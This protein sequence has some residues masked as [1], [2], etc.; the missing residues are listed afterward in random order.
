VRR[1]CTTLLLAICALTLPGCLGRTEPESTHVSG[2]VLTIYSSLPSHGPAAPMAAAI[3][4]GERLALAEAGGEAGG[5]HIRLEQLDS[6][7]QDSPLWSPD[8]ISANADRAVKDPTTIA[9]LGELGFGATAVSLPITNAAGLLQVSPTDGL[10]SLTRTPPGR[11]R[12]GP[13][14][15]YPSDMRSFLRLVPDDLL[16]TETLLGRV[17]ATGAQRLAVIYDA[18]IYGRELA[19]EI[20]ARARRDGPSP[21]ASEEYTGE[22]DKVP[23]LMQTLAE[24]HPDVVV[25]AGVAGPGTG[26]L[27]AGIDRTLPGVPL[28][29]TSGILM[30]DPARPIPAAP[31]RVEALGAIPPPSRIPRMGR[32]ILRDVAR[33]DGP[34][35][36]RPEALYGY[37]AMK[38]VLDA[39]HRAGPNRHGVI[40]S[41]LRIRSRDSAIG[42][43]SIRATGDVDNEAFAVYDLRRGRFVFHGMER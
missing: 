12:A 28:Y 4:A 10:T 11:P 39:V 17:N 15:Y 32:R 19:G 34:R 26:P 23:D 25:Y 1:T 29:A 30:R 36:A 16:E 24:A 9:Y 40:K 22:V 31:E 7:D 38:V 2:D 35:A 42:R 18:D 27:L 6:T 14:R 5:R 41:A 13:E 20:V 8:A 43:Y 33:R 3:A 21:V 37:E